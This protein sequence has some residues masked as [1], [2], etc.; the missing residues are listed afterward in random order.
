MTSWSP[1]QDTA[2]R[3]VDEWLKSDDQQVFRLFGYA[4]TGKTTLARH[5]AEGVSGHVLFGAYTGKASHV[6]RQKGCEGATTIHQMIY[7][8]KEKSQALLRELEREL[9]EVRGEM[10]AEMPPEDRAVQEVV[11]RAMDGSR[12]VQ[13]LRR[14]IQDERDAQAQ[15]MFTLNTESPVRRASLVI[16]DECSM[17]DD[18]M[19]EDLLSFGTK[20]LV[21]GDPAQLPPVVGA[22]FFTEGHEPDIMLT[23]IHRQARDNPIIAMA[24]EVRQ[25]RALAVGSYGESQV[26]EKAHVNEQHALEADQ[27]LVGRNRTRTATNHRMR[28]LLKRQENG[29][30]P[31]AED[32]LV[33]LHNNHDMGLMN[34]AIWNV[35]DVG[36]LSEERVVMTIESEDSGS[37][38]LVEAHAGIFRGEDIPWYEKREA[39]QFDYGYALTV[40]KSQGSQFNNVLLFDESY[41]FRKDRWRWL[42]TGITR[43]AERVTVVRM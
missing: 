12:T 7:H 16:I 8:S 34:G 6:L 38:Q 36:E 40:H 5:F 33:C 41:C 15:P 22:G 14:K 3:R 10:L 17:I 42:Y 2:L 32:R 37:Q 43:A 29:M 4:G 20:V 35:R 21:L 18:R 39:Q 13:T 31:V 23:E 19:G 25:E 24:T 28:F 1:E 30:L 26:A 27:I 9:V 11:D